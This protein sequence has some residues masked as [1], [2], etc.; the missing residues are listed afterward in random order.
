MGAFTAIRSAIALIKG[1]DGI[2]QSINSSDLV[3][4]AITM[5]GQGAKKG[6]PGIAIKTRDVKSRTTTFD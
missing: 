3:T 6:S 2:E 1:I 4:T 5:R